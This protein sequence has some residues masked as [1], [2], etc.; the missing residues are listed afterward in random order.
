MN[1]SMKPAI[2]ENILSSLRLIVS[3]EDIEGELKDDLN[4]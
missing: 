3:I 4:R 2:H 1:K